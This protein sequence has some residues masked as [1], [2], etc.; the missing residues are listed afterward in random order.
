MIAGL[1]R[2]LVP[3]LPKTLAAGL[4]CT[5]SLTAFARRVAIG[6]FQLSFMGSG[7]PLSFSSYIKNTALVLLRCSS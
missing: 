6:A 7:L 2:F 4:P 5:P 1:H 3:S